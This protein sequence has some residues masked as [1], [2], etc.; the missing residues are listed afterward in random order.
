METKRCAYCHK[1]QRASARTCS[2]CGKPFVKKLQHAASGAY[3]YTHPS[4]PPASPHRAG[5]YSGLHPEDQPFFSSKIIVRRIPAPGKETYNPYVPHH[6][7]QQEPELI[8]LPDIDAA[9]K[10]GREVHHL[11]SPDRSL[12]QFIAMP[13]PRSLLSAA[14]QP[15]FLRRLI[16]AILT[17]ACLGLL[18]T[19]SILA[20]VFIGKRAPAV[21]ATAMLKANPDS[22]LR[23]HDVFTL[24]GSGFSGQSLMTFT[25]DVGK[26]IFSERGNPLTTHTDAQGKF[27]VQ[28]PVSAD[29][30][31]GPHTVYAVNESQKLS[32][33]THIVIQAAST[34]TPQLRLLG[35]GSDLAFAAEAPGVVSRKSVI[36]ANNGG[37][38]I[39]WSA[40]SD[41]PW[42]T[43]SPPSDMFSGRQEVQVVVNRASL[44]PRLY[45]GHLLFKA[46]GGMPALTLH[47][48][49]R[50]STATPVL[51]ITAPVLN[52]TATTARAPADQVIT[53]QN[54]GTQAL[55]WQGT[56]A[57]G[58]G[59][60]WLSI[61]PARGS[62][63]PNA[64]MN[65]LVSIHARQ[66][67]TGTYQ[68]WISL[69][70]GASAVITV[71][72]VVQPSASA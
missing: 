68:G 58:D 55:A 4:L 49:M 66:M 16:P 9:A 31:P 13:R 47:V 64:S 30:S 37:G 59:T 44:Q 17:I 39:A 20:F 7:P 71:H 67:P 29:W 41:Q 19:S 48:T 70:G 52:F 21:T 10:V 43:V 15:G 3:G 51:S 18:L 36:L 22:G 69:S 24:S 1:L 27:Q 54:N 62:L 14:T 25:L 5:H 63:E 42:L 6:L 8:I 60:T 45:S 32:I 11:S 65:V 26:T 38:Q 34:A 46:E 23:S 56:L 12:R 2:R 33:S 61:T 40:V 28:I 50:V 35:A 57:T 72:Y 53:L